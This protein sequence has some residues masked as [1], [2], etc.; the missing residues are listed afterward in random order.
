MCSPNPGPGSI[1]NHKH[2]H[3]PEPLG[4]PA[5]S[6]LLLIQLCYKRAAN[7]EIHNLFTTH[8]V[9]YSFLIRNGVLIFNF[10]ICKHDICNSDSIDTKDVFLDF[11]IC[12]TF[13][14]HLASVRRQKKPN[15]RGLSA[16]KN[17]TTRDFSLNKNSL[18]KN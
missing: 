10:R 5:E 18:V 8:A 4:P 1:P 11:S 2:Q 17:C 14:K 12:I 15:H 13:C 3:S 6:P 7:E 16:C 9:K